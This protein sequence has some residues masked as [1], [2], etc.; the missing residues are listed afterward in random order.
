MLDV[1]LW[2]ESLNGLNGIK[3]GRQ[4]DY[5]LAVNSSKLSS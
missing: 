5:H 3:T 2:Q 4:E 1:F